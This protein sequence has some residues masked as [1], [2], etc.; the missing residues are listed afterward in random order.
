M[1]DMLNEIDKFDKNVNDLF[2]SLKSSK[3][4]TGKCFKESLYILFYKFTSI[5]K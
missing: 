1:K 2:A 4:K 3:K 5:V